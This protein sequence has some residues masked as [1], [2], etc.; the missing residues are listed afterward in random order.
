MA[1]D[2][3]Q[4]GTRTLAHAVTYVSRFSDSFGDHYTRNVTN[5]RL[6]FGDAQ[7]SNAFV[8]QTVLVLCGRVGFLIAKRLSKPGYRAARRN[9]QHVPVYRCS[10][11]PSCAAAAAIGCK[12]VSRVDLARQVTL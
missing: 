5:G 12:C 8:S 6:G 7:S 3:S 2:L 10:S 1:E 4:L 11:V 9:K